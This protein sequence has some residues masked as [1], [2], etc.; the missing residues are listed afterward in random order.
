MRSDIATPTQCELGAFIPLLGIFFAVRDP[1]LF[2]PQLSYIMIAAAGIVPFCRSTLERVNSRGSKLRAPPSWDALTW[3]L[4]RPLHLRSIPSS[5]YHHKGWAQGWPSTKRPC[6]WL[7]NLSRRNWLS[8]LCFRVPPKFFST[9]S[10]CTQQRLL[11]SYIPW[12]RHEEVHAI[13][14][15]MSMQQLLPL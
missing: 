15:N 3:D 11:H 12:Q 13:L 1:F 10:S 2:N 7:R 9:F 6:W 4:C 14:R 8:H 5:H